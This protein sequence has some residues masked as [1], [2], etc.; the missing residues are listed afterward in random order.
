MINKLKNNKVI[1][2]IVSTIVYFVAQYKGVNDDWFGTDELDIMVLGKGIARGQLLY[3]DAISQH[4]PISYY[5]SALFE[6]LGCHTVDE[7]RLAFYA[8]FAL[9]WAFVFVHY[10]KYFDKRVLFFYPLFF[11]CVIVTYDMGTAILSEHI[12]G[13]GF[14]IL[15]LEILKFAK[16]KKLDVMSCIMISFSVLLTLGTLFVSIYAIFTAG[17][18]VLAL[19]IKW[20]IEEK[21]KAKEWI[22]HMFKR[23]IPLVIIGAIP[24]IILLVY[25]VCTGTLKDFIFGAYTQNRVYYSQYMDIG[26][27]TLTPFFT[28]FG[29]LMYF[30]K[31][32]FPTPGY[33]QLVQAVFFLSLFV[34]VLKKWKKENGLLAIIIL[35]FTLSL[36]VRAAFSY[37][38]THFV[39]VLS[40]M[41]T[42][43]LIE[44]IFIDVKTFKNRKMYKQLA[45]SFL[46]VFMAAGYLFDIQQFTTIDVNSY[47]IVEE[48]Q[49]LDE[50]VDE[51]EG[52]ACTT[53]ANDILMKA[54]RFPEKGYPTT[55]WT[56]EAYKNRFEKDMEN[57]PK[58]VI[59]NCEHEVW[60]NLQSV[61]APE[62]YTFMNENYT[63]YGETRIYVLNDYYDTLY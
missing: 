50:L 25:Y 17:L 10:S 14:I 3:R 16:L 38:G 26:E 30:F 11:L 24:W 43:I 29:H 59:Y 9:I 42:S 7:Q 52:V 58:V 55:P 34:Y 23:Y 53:F 62:F 61:Y 51:D 8:F 2:F 56:W 41:F 13:C 20:L 5:I 33:N 46:V 44:D 48:A 27:N 47:D 32:L 35:C 15:F 31:G 1:L 57:P 21:K 22:A 63:R 54:D 60:G 36:A 12:A 37:H 45:I 40:L 49:I 4:M 28:P 18:G 39:E 19:E 6:K